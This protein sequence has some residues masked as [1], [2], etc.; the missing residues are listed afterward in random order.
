MPWKFKLQGFHHLNFCF[1]ALPWAQTR[2]LAFRRPWKQ[3]AVP[4]ERSEQKRII[5]VMPPLRRWYRSTLEISWGLTNK[6]PSGRTWK[7]THT[8]WRRPKRTPVLRPMVKMFFIWMRKTT[9]QPSGKLS[10]WLWIARKRLATEIDA[11]RSYK[12]YSS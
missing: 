3:S 11:L 4:R 5:L 8:I 6:R 10:C 12:N 1:A 7:N 9:D 2:H